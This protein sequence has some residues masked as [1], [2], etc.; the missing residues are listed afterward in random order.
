M[1]TREYSEL[2][3]SYDELMELCFSS[4]APIRLNTPWANDLYMMNEQ[5]FDE[6]MKG[7]DTSGFNIVLDQYDILAYREKVQIYCE[8]LE[9]P[10]FVLAKNK[11]VAF[12]TDVIFNYIAGNP[13][14][15]KDDDPN[16]IL[17]RRGHRAFHDRGKQLGILIPFES[18]FKK[19]E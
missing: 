18:A 4:P 16:I 7:Y 6:L 10:I 11:Y 17:V 12:M 2:Y 5:V 1:I 14:E 3:D 15:Y 13:P 8:E 9:E 19:K